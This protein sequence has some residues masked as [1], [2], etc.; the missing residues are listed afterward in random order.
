MKK[1]FSTEVESLE[2]KGFVRSSFQQQQDVTNSFDG[3]P[4]WNGVPVPGGGEPLREHPAAVVL[5]PTESTRSGVLS[6]K[7]PTLKCQM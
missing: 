4:V 5:F 1:L 7:E 6:E 2:Q 3:L